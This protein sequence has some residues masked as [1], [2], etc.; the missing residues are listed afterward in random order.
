MNYSQEVQHMCSL[1]KGPKHGPAPIPEE[2]KWIQAKE[3][4]DIRLTHTVQVGVLPS[5]ALVSSRSMLKTVSSR[6]PSLKQSVARV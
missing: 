5:R 3:I 6:K 2:G 1:A 4:S